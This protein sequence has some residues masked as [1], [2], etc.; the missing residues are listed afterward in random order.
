MASKES[1]SGDGKLYSIEV[2]KT[3]AIIV[4]RRPIYFEYTLSQGQG[5]VSLERPHVSLE[6]GNG[7]KA[8]TP[9]CHMNNNNR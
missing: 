8:E 4:F 1:R 5:N 2:K 6:Y 3:S 7:K 9:I